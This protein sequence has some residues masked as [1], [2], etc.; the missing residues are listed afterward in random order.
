MSVKDIAG[1]FKALSDPTR[2]RIVLLLLR[3]HELCVCEIMHV[4]GMEQSRVSH[5]M[6]ILRHAGLVEDSREGRWINYRISKQGRPL[7]EDLFAGTLGARMEIAPEAAEDARKLEA[8][9]RE[10]IRGR[11][12]ETNTRAEA[13][14]NDR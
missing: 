4:L 1:A 2:L 11:S 14:E 12:C 3:Q 6:R 8:C 9:I 10:N 7:I 5:Q 13:Q